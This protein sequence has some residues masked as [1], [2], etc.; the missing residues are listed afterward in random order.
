M[1]FL[2][3]IFIIFNYISLIIFISCI[4]HQIKYQRNWGWKVLRLWPLLTLH[5]LHPRYRDLP[6]LNYSC[7]FHSPP[8]DGLGEQQMDNYW[9]HTG[10]KWQYQRFSKQQMV[11][12]VHFN[13]PHC[14]PFHFFF[15]F[16]INKQINKNGVWK[17]CITCPI[18]TTD[19]SLGHTC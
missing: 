15:V 5:A 4:T 9:M 14:R 10:G 16:K 19:L 3:Y 11:D 8:Q 1:S 13:Q 2:W 12:N 18:W 6:Q 7:A 17:I